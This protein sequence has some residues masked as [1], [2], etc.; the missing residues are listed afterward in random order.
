MG[1]GIAELK[2]Q[3]IVYVKHLY[4][5]LNVNSLIMPLRAGTNKKTP[6]SVVGDRLLCG[7]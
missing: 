7:D 4:Y 3:R 2:N 1:S 6:F 5:G